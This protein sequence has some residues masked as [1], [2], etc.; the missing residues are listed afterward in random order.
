MECTLLT[1]SEKWSCSISLRGDGINTAFSPEIT[2][3]ADVELWIRRAQAAVLCPHLPRERFQSM[4]REEIRQAT[5]H[6]MDRKVRRFSDTVV[7]VKILDPNGTDLVF[8]DLPGA[9]SA[10]SPDGF[11]VLKLDMGR[12]MLCAA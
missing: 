5:D 3:K 6:T 12:C 1:S 11:S 7:E 10:R 8:V 4:S 9:C 2:A